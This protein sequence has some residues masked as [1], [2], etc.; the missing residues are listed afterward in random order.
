MDVRAQA[1]GKRPL[2]HPVSVAAS[3]HFRLVLFV[4]R[5]L[6][7][8]LLTLIS[9]PLVRS[10]ALRNSPAPQIMVRTM[11]FLPSQLKVISGD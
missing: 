8:G 3:Q 1:P 4:S 7:R 6:L 9:P 10:L 5:L 2:S 11:G